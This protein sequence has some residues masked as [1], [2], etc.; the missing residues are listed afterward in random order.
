MA[1]PDLWQLR[2]DL[3][4]CCPEPDKCSDPA[5]CARALREIGEHAVE[6]YLTYCREPDASRRG[7]AEKKM[8]DLRAVCDRRKPWVRVIS[9][10]LLAPE[11]GSGPEQWRRRTC[12][13]PRAV[14]YEKGTM[15][16]VD[17]VQAGAAA[18]SAYF[19]GLIDVMQRLEKSSRRDLDQAVE[20]CAEAVARGRRLYI[21]DTRRMLGREVANRSGGLVAFMTVRPNS[22]TVEPL[23][24]PI[25]E[26]EPGGVLIVCSVTGV[27]HRSVQAALT[28]RQM[29][30]RTIALTSR[31]FSTNLPPEHP[32]GQRLLDAVDLVLD[33]GAEYGDA[34]LTLPGF[35]RKVAATSGI[36][37]AALLGALTVGVT[38]RLLE[39]G[40][41]PSVY[42]SIHL[43]GGQEDVAHSEERYQRLGH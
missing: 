16:A 20:L 12:A 28:A 4:M 36:A 42:Q 23:A 43:P 14:T 10:A 9:S 25:D 6:V 32:S 26:L 11:A 8:A 13:G 17:V 21:Y 34:F 22:S 41:E 31:T 29:G 2:H 39:R 3:V 40:I 15:N 24:K 30:C 37:G 1:R 27:S 7:D 38:E 19:A 35:S 5:D 18:R 33:N